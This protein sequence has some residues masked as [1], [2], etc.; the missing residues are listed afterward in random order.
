MRRMRR[1]RTCG[2]EFRPKPTGRTPVYCSP[3]C[4]QRAYRERHRLRDDLERMQKRDRRREQERR[5]RDERRAEE[6]D[7]LR[8]LYEL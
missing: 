3:S 7:Q 1:C 2:I 8:R 5:E 4:R 6:V